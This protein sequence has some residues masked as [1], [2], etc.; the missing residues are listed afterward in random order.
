MLKEVGCSVCMHEIITLARRLD[1]DG[2]G[3]SKDV[4]YDEFSLPA[5]EPETTTEEAHDPTSAEP[6]H[7]HMVR[8]LY[9]ICKIP[10]PPDTGH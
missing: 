3:I 7:G 8:Y 6:V 4:M 1:T 9:S 2:A 10:Q 5:F